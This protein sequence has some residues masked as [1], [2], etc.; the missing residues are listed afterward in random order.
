MFACSSGLQFN[1][2]SHP[3]HKGLAVDDTTFSQCSEKLTMLW[4]NTQEQVKALRIFTPWRDEM[5]D[6][7]ARRRTWDNLEKF[8][9]MN[10]V[11]VLVGQDV[12]C[13]ETSDEEQWLL[14]LELMRR[15]G[16]K[17]IMGVAIG[18]E[19]DIFYQ[20]VPQQ[21]HCIKKLWDG[22]R[23]WAT[24][25]DR[26]ADLDLNGFSGVPVT[27]VWASSILGTTTTPFISTPQA[28]VNDFVTKAHKRYGKRWVW[29]ATVYPIWDPS[30]LPPPWSTGKVC[31]DIIAAVTDMDIYMGS[32]IYTYRQRIQ[33]ITNDTDDIFWLGE[34]GWSSPAPLGLPPHCKDFTSMKTF[35]K[36][37]QNFLEW[38]MTTVRDAKSNKTARGPDHAFYFTIRDAS[39]F[40]FEEHFGLLSSCEATQCKLQPAKGSLELTV[41]V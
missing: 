11:Q 3:A 34:T 40:G 13:N 19:M 2:A 26:V 28:R 32:L 1:L 29:T 35:E 31:N 24:F 7:I 38:N 10:G 23:Y 17:H 36:F 18:N 39:N 5:G 22:G 37:Y 21:P 4:P 16:K 6:A 8:V 41:S 20:K 14:N 25:Q 15:L 9:K 30:V 12:T 33:K 27:V